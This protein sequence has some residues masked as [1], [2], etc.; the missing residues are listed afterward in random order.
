MAPLLETSDLS[1]TFGGLHALDDVSLTV[2]EGSFVG[3]IGPNG[4]GKTTFVD[5]ITG[6]VPYRGEVRFAE[7]ALVRARPHRRAAAGLVRTFQSLELFDD[8]TVRE[9]LL[10]SHEKPMW[11]SMFVDAVRPRSG[12]SDPDVNGA[13]ELLDLT[14][15][16]DRMPTELPHGVRKLVGVGRALAGDPRF[17][18]LDEPAAG[19]DSEESIELGERLKTL[20]E[21][22]ITILMVDHDMAL[23]LGVCDPIWVL[24][25]GKVIGC[26]PPNAIQRDPAVVAAYLGEQGGS[27]ADDPAPTTGTTPA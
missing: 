7:R 18:V 27:P 16:A 5:A 9:N 19:L 20:T 23:V 1:V 10:V 3:L 22:G 24:D 6:F 2:E 8:L 14:D 12:L 21:H 4:A 11:W 26:G 13:L 15:V 17:L 25:F